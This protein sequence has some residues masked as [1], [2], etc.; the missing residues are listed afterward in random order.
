MSFR[1]D[2]IIQYGSLHGDHAVCWRRTCAAHLIVMCA[3]SVSHV[4]CREERHGPSALLRGGVEALP[5][6]TASISS[7]PSL[8]P[9]CSTRT[10]LNR[11]STAKR[12]SAAGRSHRKIGSQLMLS[13]CSLYQGWVVSLTSVRTCT[14]RVPARCSWGAV[15]T[16]GEL[17][18]SRG[19]W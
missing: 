3:L 7:H 8:Q 10:D 18:C 19:Q 11:I 16:K 9:A 6:S 12:E 5:V 1:G 14:R 2:S 15:S 13:S 4:C 17:I